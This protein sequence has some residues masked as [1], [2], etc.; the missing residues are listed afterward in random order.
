MALKEV[1]NFNKYS[2]DTAIIGCLSDQSSFVSYLDEID[3]LNKW[4]GDFCLTLNVCK[5]REMILDLR[6]GH[7]HEPATIN[8]DK[9]EIVNK[10]K[11]MGT[12]IDSKLS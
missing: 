1:C 11:Y 7:N 12:I 4:C 5:T 6:K 8:G 3:A 2:D 9:M 10:F